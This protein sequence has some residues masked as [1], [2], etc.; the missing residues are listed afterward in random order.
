MRASFVT[1]AACVTL[2]SGAL[3]GAPSRADLHKTSWGKPS[4]SFEQ[5]RTDAVECAVHASNYDITQTAVGQRLLAFNKQR[6]IARRD[7]W[8]GWDNQWG[9]DHVGYAAD[10]NPRIEHFYDVQYLDTRDL[11]YDLLGKCLSDRG[12]RQF[13]LTAH[14]IKTLDTLRRGSDARQDYLYRLASDPVVMAHQ[15][16]KTL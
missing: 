7:G 13:R 16:L 14:Q 8:M 3:A 1:L 6:E 5:Y 9:G 10:S 2:A 15:G 12:Y 11:Q 4:V